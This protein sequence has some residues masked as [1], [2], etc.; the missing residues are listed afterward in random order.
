MCK[1]FLLD[2][3]SPTQDAKLGVS[4]RTVELS[5]HMH[6]SLY[7]VPRDQQFPVR[8]PRHLANPLTWIRAV[9]LHRHG[10]P[11]REHRH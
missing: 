4:A 10:R 9:S 7:V 11:G 8:P 1:N 6:F 3:P 5:G 2:F